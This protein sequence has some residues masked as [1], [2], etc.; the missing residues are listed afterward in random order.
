MCLKIFFKNYSTFRIEQKMFK[1]K[2]PH[3]VFILKIMKTIFRTGQ[4]KYLVIHQVNRNSI[5]V[6]ARNSRGWGKI[7]DIKGTSNHKR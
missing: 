4:F 5:S 7:V 1:K 6:S 3:S 2:N